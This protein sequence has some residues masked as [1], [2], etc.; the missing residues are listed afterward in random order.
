MKV[1]ELYEIAV[2]P[3]KRQADKKNIWL[4]YVVRPLSIWVTLLLLNTKISPTAI[5]KLSVVSSVIAFFL[6]TMGHN[7]MACK[8]IGWILFFVWAVLDCVDGNL[9]R[10][11][12]QCSEDGE[13]WDALGGYATMI[14]IYYAAS[15]VSFFDDNIV[16]LCEN[17]WML[18]FGTAIVVFSL[19]PRLIMHKKQCIYGDANAVVEL[20]DKKN[21]GLVK[22]F[23]M[24]LISVIGL[25]QVFFFCGILFH[26]LNIFIVFYCVVNF[27]MMVL[28]LHKVLK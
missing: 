24:N 23:A 28:S 9:A 7:Y 12:N 22:T 2:S 18:I 20:S 3:N 25:L 26:C 15:I 6:M 10:A 17:Y 14:L 21:Y 4:Y 8:I 16:P 27:L 19:F 11:R 13:L 5:T 1:K